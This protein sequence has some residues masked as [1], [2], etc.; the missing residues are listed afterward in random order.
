MDIEQ[1]IEELKEE[2]L[3]CWEMDFLES[4]EEQFESIGSLSQK[5]QDKLHEIYMDKRR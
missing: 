2:I 4:V 1:T 3:T 5:Q